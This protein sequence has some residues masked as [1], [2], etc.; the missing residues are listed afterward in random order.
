MTEQE[1]FERVKNYI[2]RKGAVTRVAVCQG[3]KLSAGDIAAVAARLQREGKINIVDPG[4]G[5]TYSWIGG[6]VKGAPLPTFN[7][8]LEKERRAEGVTSGPSSPAD[9]VTPANHVHKSLA[10]VLARDVFRLKDMQLLLA[11][12]TVAVGRGDTSMVR[13]KLMSMVDEAI[14]WRREIVR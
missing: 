3:T 11:D 7:P 8:P 1:I 9:P 4:R 13:E 6:T 14:V 12:L 10:V 2:E 5:E